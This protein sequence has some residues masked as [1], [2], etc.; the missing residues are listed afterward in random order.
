MMDND[1]FAKAKKLPPPSPGLTLRV[2][3]EVALEWMSLHHME[4]DRFYGDQLIVRREES[5]VE[6]AEGLK[7]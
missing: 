6:F 4:K 5:V 2:S 3:V 7:T 1:A